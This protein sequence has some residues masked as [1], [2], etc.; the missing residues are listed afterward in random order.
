MSEPI[1]EDVKFIEDIAQVLE[2]LNTMYDENGHAFKPENYD[3]PPA[4]L[5]EF[6]VELVRMDC[7]KRVMMGQLPAPK[8]HDMVE[9]V[10]KAFVMGV[11][12]SRRVLTHNV[13]G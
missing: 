6:M 5:L 11:L 7:M 12:Y 3:L 1:S 10:S 13:E 4:A 8:P 2:S 9:L